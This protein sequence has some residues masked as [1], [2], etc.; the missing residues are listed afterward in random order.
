MSSSSS[1]SSPLIPW[2]S[3][4][5]SLELE[6]MI[7]NSL[8]ENILSTVTFSSNTS[9]SSSTL[10]IP[11][12]PM[13]SDIMYTEF[14]KTV[15]FSEELC[16]LQHKYSG[17]DPDNGDYF[18]GVHVN[19]LQNTAN[20][21]GI[22]ADIGQIES[23]KHSIWDFIEELQ[24]S[25][26]SAHLYMAYINV[27]LSKIKLLTVDNVIRQNL[28]RIFRRF[29]S[30]NGAIQQ[31][32]NLDD[33]MFIKVYKVFHLFDK[34]GIFS[35]RLGSRNG[36]E[37]ME[38]AR[39]ILMGFLLDT[40]TG[41][42]TST[43][44]TTATGAGNTGGN[45]RVVTLQDYEEI[46]DGESNSSAAIILQMQKQISYLTSLVGKGQTSSSSNN[47]FSS[48]IDNIQATA[49]PQKSPNRGT[50]GRT[51]RSTVPIGPLVSSNTISNP[52]PRSTSG[53]GAISIGGSNRNN[54]LFTQ[55]QYMSKSGGGKPNDSDDSS[56]DDDDFGGNGNSGSSGIKKNS[57]GSGSNSNSNNN[58]SGD[59]LDE[60]V[61][62]SFDTSIYMN[63]CLVSEEA[64]AKILQEQIRSYASHEQY[65]RQELS[66]K[67]NSK[68]ISFEIGRLVMLCDAIHGL[69]IGNNIPSNFRLHH[70]YELI[71]RMIMGL[72]IAD[73]NGTYDTLEG[74]VGQQ[75]FALP[76]SIISQLNKA[77]LQG[78]KLE[79][80]KVIDTTTAATG[81]F[82][83][84]N[85]SNRGNG[86]F[87]YNNR[88]GGGTGRGGN[89]NQRG[90]GQNNGNRGGYHNN[91]NNNNN[92][93]N[94]NHGNVNHGN[95]ANRG[96]GAGGNAGAAGRE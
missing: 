93:N 96:G 87:H 92:H 10:S 86:G 53:T 68:Q 9:S 77:R 48:L 82:N 55:L 44:G 1:S 71:S 65:Y 35:V 67:L 56:D 13:P 21:L 16:T 42:A 8:P 76:V 28:M 75:K 41:T 22:E 38:S 80:K 63:G 37:K 61:N 27:F 83:R 11:L 58:G 33:S 30:A 52:R 46:S 36:K 3:D 62:E 59:G 69:G 40:S 7:K 74:L 54:N 4:H 17:V 79:S 57:I 19:Y 72:Q 43:T 78:K 2:T 14:G 23:Y 66:V 25:D 84:S 88:R 34:N 45:N 5:V 49:T 31:L 39:A 24:S 26:V 89:N 20:R 81:T 90:G 70:I 50:G 29:L 85:Q 18:A 12:I 32:P 15:I 6:R 47:D 91:N 51:T 94:N 73:G 60:F 95:N 64:F